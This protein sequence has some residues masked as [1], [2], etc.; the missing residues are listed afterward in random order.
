MIVETKCYCLKKKL[1]CQH[2]SQKASQVVKPLFVLVFYFFNHNL[3]YFVIVLD[4]PEN[5]YDNH[6][7][8]RIL[9]P[10]GHIKSLELEHEKRPFSAKVEFQMPV[11]VIPNRYKFD[12]LS[13]N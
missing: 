4:I 10:Y 6:I 5:D 9:S 13:Y 11:S 1:R 12:F 7:L 2:C 3:F 8:F